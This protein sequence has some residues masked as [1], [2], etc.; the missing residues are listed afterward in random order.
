MDARPRRHHVVTGVTLSED[1]D[2]SR[3]TWDVTFRQAVTT[4]E[5][6]A[7][8]RAHHARP[9]TAVVLEGPACSDRTRP[10]DALHVLAETEDGTLADVAPARRARTGRDE[11]EGV[12]DT[13]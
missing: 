12:R 9:M 8:V 5:A 10:P 13:P 1:G 7:R 6:L 11:T 3:E 2:V 4:D